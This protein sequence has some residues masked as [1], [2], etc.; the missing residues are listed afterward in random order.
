MTAMTARKASAK[1]K[2]GAKKTSAKKAP[3]KKK[4]SSR[5]GTPKK[6]PAKK[7]AAKNDAAAKKKKKKKTA[8]RSAPQKVVAEQ[9]PSK[10][11]SG[12]SSTQVMMGHMFA[13]RPRVSTSFRPDD[14]RRARQ[15]LADEP[16]ANIQDAARA[17][18]EK[19]HELTRGE[20]KGA[21][22]SKRF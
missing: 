16:Y 19:A 17:V 21:R 20:R 15:S 13:L 18:A 12:A 6:S 22:K 2:A 4:T 5:K 1:K 10:A 3:S 8:S 9:K 7:A 11:R 14:F